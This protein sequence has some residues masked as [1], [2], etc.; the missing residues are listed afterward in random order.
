MVWVWAV[1]WIVVHACI[2]KWVAFSSGAICAAVD[3]EAEYRAHAVPIRGRKSKEFCGN[4]YACPCL[5]KTDASG[6][7]RMCAVAV[8]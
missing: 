3:V 4:E 7:I 1:V 6:N 5:V 8:H 2:G